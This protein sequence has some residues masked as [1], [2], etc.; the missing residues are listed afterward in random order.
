MIEAEALHK[1][2]RAVRALDGF[3]F[4]ARDGE[5]TA[6]V[7]PNGAGKT[8]ALRI[9]YTVMRADKGWARIDGFDTVDARRQAQRRIGALADSR[10]LYAR[11]TGREHIRYYGRLHGMNGS[12]LEARIDTLVEALGMTEFAERRAKG[13]S[14][15][16]SLKIALARALVHEPANLL[17]DEPTNGLD[18]ASSRAVRALLR[19][20]RDEGRCVL[21]CTHIMAEVAAVCDRLVIIAEGRAVAQGT[22]DELRART[23]HDDLEDVFL[24][25]TDQASGA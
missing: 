6:L 7:G 8:T 13:F 3:G 12:R 25:L 10:G 15:G 17:L 1:T 5:I 14:K 23:G 16:Q 22:P 2:F 20:A 21:F 11:L 18:I 24:A 4:T 9:L 19:G